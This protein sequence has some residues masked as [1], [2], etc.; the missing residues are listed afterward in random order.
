MALS[1]VIAA[2]LG[3]IFYA[4]IFRPLRDA[5][6]IAKAVASIGLMIVLPALIA[7]RV[8]TEIVAVE[9][10]FALDSIAIGARQAPTDRIWLAATIIAIA[11]VATLVFRFSRFGI[12][13]EAAAESEK[14]AY[15]TGLSPDRIAFSNW[16]LSSVVA[17]SVASS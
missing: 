14:G 3:L 13:T 16:A 1:L 2:L 6:V 4:L 10:I 5:P 7:L 8:G 9:P 12:A 11:V 15:L 17:G